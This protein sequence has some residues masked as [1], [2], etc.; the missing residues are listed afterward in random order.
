MQ[1]SG[2]EA[3]RYDHFSM[4]P[5]LAFQRRPFGGMTLEGGKGGGASAPAPDPNI[6]IAQRELS[7]ISREYLESWK[8]DV[9]PS[10]KEE[11][12]KQ[13]ARADEQFALDRDIQLR[14]KE[15]AEIEGVDMVLGAAEKFRIVEFISDLTKQPKTIFIIVLSK[16]LINLYHPILTEIEPEH[17]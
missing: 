16:K 7:Q 1:I 17:S 8:T 12:Q 5:E 11:S 15:I 3:M 9:W 14:Q 10:L 13:T 2:D 6:G 4:L